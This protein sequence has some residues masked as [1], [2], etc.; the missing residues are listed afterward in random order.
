VS[1]K[2][3]E[4]CDKRGL[5][6]L[7]VR[8][9]VAPMGAGAP[10]AADLPITLGARAAHYTKRVLRSGYVY[11]YDEARTRLE[12]YF[13]TADGYYFRMLA[14]PGVLPVVPAKPFNCPDA[15]HREIASCITI[16]DPRHATTV[17]VGFSDVRWTDAIRAQ[18]GDAQVRARHMRQ[19]NVQAALAGGPINHA[20][21]IASVQSLVAEYALDAAAGRAALGWGPFAFLS[22]KSGAAALVEKCESLR[23]GRGLILTLEDPAGIAQE[24]PALMARNAQLF[25]DDPRRMR[26]LAISSAIQQIESAVK[27]NAETAEVDAAET[28]ANQ[29]VTNNPLGHA[30]F[31]STRRQTETLREVT[32]AE[33]DRAAASAWQQYT[34]KYNEAARRR[35]QDD[36]DRQFADFDTGF[37]APLAS[38]HARWMDSE[39]MHQMVQGNF[40]PSSIESGIVLTRLFEAMTAGT[41]DK[42]A[43]FDLYGKW[44]RGSVLDRRNLLLRALVCNQ[45]QLAKEVAEAARSSVD[46]NGLPWDK[47]IEAVTKATERLMAGE[48][49][50]LGRVVASVA[51]PATRLFLDAAVHPRVYDAFV[52]FGMA[53]RHPVVAVDIIGGK[54]AFRAKLIRQMLQISGVGVSERQLRKAVADEL[55]RLAIHGITLEGTEKKRFY[56]LVDAA[57]VRNMP[58]GL[59][60]QAQAQ[61]LAR[62]IRTPEQIEELDL[63]NWRRRVEGIG[64]AGVPL[65]FGVLG[66]V[67]QY[68]ALSSLREEEAKAMQHNRSE[69]LRRIYA[70]GVQVAGAVAD[71][72][73]QGLNRVVLQVPK[74]G[75]GLLGRLAAALTASG[76]RLG[77]G[78]SLVMAGL[79]L[80]RGAKELDE[81]NVP[82]GVGFLVAGGLGFAATFLLAAGWTGWGLLVVAALIAWSFLMTVL[83]DN[84]IQDWLERV[85]EW[86]N[87]DD[88]RYPDFATEQR[89]LKVALAD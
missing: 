17:W 35:W 29:Q 40:D 81:N 74:L 60:K 23:P 31:E 22:R 14:T 79:D 18:H 77:L 87:L 69:S 63:I 64:R 5:P 89:E 42:K 15:G 27:S 72:L 56:R 24:L 51:G 46:I 33:A 37:I 32:P 86:G 80:Y 88:Q 2:K 20:A 9:A 1:D 54:K 61:W 10:R 68:A 82:A 44:L 30:L 47:V 53:A 34:K 43:C 58:A 59:S 4:F 13:V 49:D 48:A 39:P 41:Q 85:H 45:D 70:Q 78:G 83:V 71:V 19:I 76:R 7:L 21:P 55:R 11:V 16:A 25:L 3:C 50:A 73:G 66:L 6:L 36:F 57:E 65:A 12:E 8:D 52:A 38:A 67:T 26:K 62:T 28:L 75:Q 84:K